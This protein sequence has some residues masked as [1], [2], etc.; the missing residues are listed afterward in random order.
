MRYSGWWRDASNPDDPSRRWTGKTSAQTDFVLDLSAPKPSRAAER[1]TRWLTE[2][3]AECRRMLKDPDAARR[4]SPSQADYARHALRLIRLTRSR[5][6]AGDAWGAA[7][8]G[9]R[10]AGHATEWRLKD[11]VQA[12]A[13]RGAKSYREAKRAAASRGREVHRKAAAA[14]AKLAREV[15]RL[16]EDH[17]MTRASA[18]AYLARKQG[19]SAAALARR[20]NRYEKRLKA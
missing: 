7:E 8:A 11:H 19:K 14:G 10:L 4:G 2:Y 18:C 1:F 20:L 12:E 6:D 16:V 17:D 15:R 3:A 13:S 5:A 9:L